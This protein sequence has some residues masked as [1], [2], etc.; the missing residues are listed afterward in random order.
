MRRRRLHLILLWLP[1]VAHAAL[2]T[3]SAALSLTAAAVAIDHRATGGVGVVLPPLQGARA[4]ARTVITHAGDVTFRRSCEAGRC[5]LLGGDEHGYRLLASYP[6]D[7]TVDL[8]A[9]PEV[10]LLRI[11]D[12]REPPD[13]SSWWIASTVVGLLA[14]LVL[15]LRILELRLELARATKGREGWVSEDGELHLALH[16]RGALVGPPVGPGPVL[17]L[18]ALVPRPEASLALAPYREAPLEAWTALPGS[19]AEHLVR[20]GRALGASELAL[21]CILGANLA[22]LVAGLVLGA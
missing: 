11:R 4:D 8:S 16:G 20:I 12:P 10:E 1:A 13:A 2:L 3:I 17:A 14:L 7:R 15:W 22:A 5:E 6:S 9:W 21:A 19:K 18:P